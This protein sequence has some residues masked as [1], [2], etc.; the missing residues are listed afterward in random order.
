MEPFPSKF[1]KV[2]QGL[3][4]G[5]QGPYSQHFTILVTYKW[6]QFAKVLHYNRMEKL[7]RDKHSSL[8][9]PFV[10]YKEVKVL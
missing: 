6:V 7:A 3:R 4:S 5:I 8:L 1:F 2:V 9:G 10:S